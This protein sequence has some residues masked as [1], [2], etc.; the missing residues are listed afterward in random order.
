[1]ENYLDKKN[2]AQVNRLTT[3]LYN[4]DSLNELAFQYEILSLTKQNMQEQAKRRYN[5]FIV[6]Y[7]TENNDDFSY[8]F[9]DITDKKPFLKSNKAD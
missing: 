3:I 8:T 7:R 9:L 4:I 1:M 6:S 5:S 2:Y